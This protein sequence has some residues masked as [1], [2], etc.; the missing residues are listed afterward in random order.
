MGRKKGGHQT[1]ADAPERAM[2]AATLRTQ[3]RKGCKAVRINMAFTPENYEFIKTMA[4]ASGQ[5]MT[6]F[7]NL[8]IS[9]HQRQHPEALAASRMFQKILKDMGLFDPRSPF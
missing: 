8:I 5:T 3:G 4:K 1:I 6:E 2:R 9:A 7:V